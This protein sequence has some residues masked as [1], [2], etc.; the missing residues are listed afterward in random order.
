MQYWQ[1][2]PRRPTRR[3]RSSQLIRGP[4]LSWVL[5]G[6]DGDLVLRVGQPCGLAMLI[7]TSRASRFQAGSTTPSENRTRHWLGTRL[8]GRC[9]TPLKSQLVKSPKRGTDA[10]VRRAGCS[11]GWLCRT[12][13]AVRNSGWRPTT[14]WSR[15]LG[16]TLGVRTAA[17]SSP[18]VPPRCVCGQRLLRIRP[19]GQPGPFS[20]WCRSGPRRRWTGPG[21]SAAGWSRCAARTA[22]A[23]AGGWE[24]I[25][26]AR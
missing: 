17:G 24:V 1:V 23:A 7:S 13:S 26:A 6:V 22:A 12:G 16:R 2:L 19:V 18:P 11:S 4:P 8:G 21:A 20:G 9:T 15:I 14:G 5:L 10:S 3:S 25:H